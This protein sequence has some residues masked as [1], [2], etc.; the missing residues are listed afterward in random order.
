MP[1]MFNPTEKEIDL[2]RALRFIDE[3]RAAI[4]NL[5]A[6]PQVRQRL[7]EVSTHLSRKQGENTAILG[8]LITLTQVFPLQCVNFHITKCT[9]EFVM[10]E[11]QFP[12]DWR[13]KAILKNDG[14]IVVEIFLAINENL[15]VPI[16][17][18][19]FAGHTLAEFLTRINKPVDNKAKQIIVKSLESI[20]SEYPWDRHYRRPLNEEQKVHVRACTERIKADLTRPI[21]S[22]YRF[23]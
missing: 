3:N 16:N 1:D 23:P 21:R 5:D 7:A 11:A 17:K 12:P 18:E 2:L 13:L 19:F 20:V 22:G 4:E 15:M 14:K 10:M 9:T 8:G 6:N